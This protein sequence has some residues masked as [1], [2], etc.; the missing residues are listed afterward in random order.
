MTDVKR[1]YDLHWPVDECGEN[2]VGPETDTLVYN[3]TTE[4]D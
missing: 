3:V 4:C 1:C 2:E